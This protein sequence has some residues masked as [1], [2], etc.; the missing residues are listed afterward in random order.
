MAGGD[1]GAGTGGRDLSRGSPER[2]NDAYISVTRDATNP[3]PTFYGAHINPTDAPM[4]SVSAP[5]LDYI[6]V[7]IGPDGTPWAAFYA[8]CPQN[9]APS[10]YC[11]Q[12][13]VPGGFVQE[14]NAIAGPLATVVGRLV[15]PN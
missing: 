12:A 5:G 8:N 13:G 10:S 6:D 14:G 4:I 2:G 11:A 7:D 3:N 1:R 9:P 15:W